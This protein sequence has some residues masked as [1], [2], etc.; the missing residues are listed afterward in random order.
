MSQT[1][2]AIDDSPDV[3]RLLDVRLRPEGL[4]L[5]HALAAE[6]GLA[7]AANV[8][9]DLIL[10]DVDMPLVTGFEVCKKLKDNPALSNV[11]IIF[12]TGAAEVHTK[13]QGFDLGAIDYVTKPFEPAE[14][15]ARVRAALR[16]KRYHDLLAARSNVDALTGIWNRSYFNQRLGDEIAAGRRYGR[17]LSLVMVDIDSFKSLNDTYGHPFGDLVLQ[18]VG[19]LLHEQLRATDAPCRY[20]GEEFGLLLSDTDEAGA[21]KTAERLRSALADHTF[22]PRDRAMRV[23]ASFGV[24]CTTLFTREMLEASALVVAADDALYEAK[25]TG[26]DRVCVARQSTVTNR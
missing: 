14:L 12:L 22:R 6:E 18:H 20:G 21:L 16:T 26:R 24:A 9:P 10:L 2:L 1:V 3:H 7:M 5:H 23:T 19:E 15:R 13:V 17:V 11:P 4:V 25:Q 8:R